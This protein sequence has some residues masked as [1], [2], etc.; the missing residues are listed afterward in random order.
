MSKP[1]LKYD[2]V[3]AIVRVDNYQTSAGAPQ[4]SITITKV[5]F[6]ESAARREVE[7]LIRLNREK[8]PAYFYQLTRL[9][10]RD[11]GVSDS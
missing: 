7:R 10:R 11:A 4:D 1:N 8:G 9:E 3:F 6:S 2:H 5:L